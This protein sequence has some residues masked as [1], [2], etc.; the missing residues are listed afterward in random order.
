MNQL[1]EEKVESSPRSDFTVVPTPRTGKYCAA[2]RDSAVIGVFIW[3][4]MFGLIFP[5]MLVAGLGLKDPI[6][7]VIV[8]ACVAFGTAIGALLT[9]GAI[10]RSQ[11][12]IN[13]HTRYDGTGPDHFHW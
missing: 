12:D 10:H 5:M 1:R 3:V 11:R 13:D 9:P 7:T 6:A 2:C 8:G 4:F